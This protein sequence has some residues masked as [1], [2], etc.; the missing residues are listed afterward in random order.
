MS[1]ANP[2]R[3]HST[4]PCTPRESQ[5]RD[6]C[7]F[8]SRVGIEDI[9][10]WSWFFPVLSVSAGVAVQ[11]AAFR[12][13]LSLSLAILSKIVSLCTTTG[14]LQC[15]SRNL[16]YLPTYRPELGFGDVGILVQ[17]R[18]QGETSL[19]L[20]SFEVKCVAFDASGLLKAVTA[21]TSRVDDWRCVFGVSYMTSLSRSE[22][23]PGSSCRIQA[24]RKCKRQVVT[25]LNCDFTSGLETGCLDNILY[26]PRLYW[27]GVRHILGR[28]RKRRE[29]EVTCVLTLCAGF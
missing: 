28:R 26:L 18:S 15:R 13:A 12:P 14:N 2:A 16:S 20:T 19:T 4:L 27:E 23:E 7:V 22:A 11:V 17:S 25:Q 8:G 6:S 24:G 29:P 1:L 5:H 9:W 21:C 3:T 10:I